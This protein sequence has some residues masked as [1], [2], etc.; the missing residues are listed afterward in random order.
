MTEHFSQVK[1]YGRQ[2]GSSNMQGPR[3]MSNDC[4]EAS[5]GLPTPAPPRGGTDHEPEG[6]EPDEQQ[7]HP[8][9]GGRV[10]LR[11]RVVVR[12]QHREHVVKLPSAHSLAGEDSVALRERRDRRAV[13][14]APLLIGRVEGSELLRLAGAEK[15]RDKARVLGKPPAA[16]LK[17]STGNADTRRGAVD[18]ANVPYE[19]RA[20]KAFIIQILK[21]ILNSG[22][23]NLPSTRAHIRWNYN[24]QSDS[25][26]P[27]DTWN[28]DVHIESIFAEARITYFTVQ[29]VN[30]NLMYRTVRLKVVYWA[31]HEQ[32]QKFKK[33]HYRHFLPLDLWIP[34]AGP[35]P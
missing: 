19:V 7:L 24:I 21:T 4:T 13:R 11:V 27:P 17:R 22:R 32:Y 25:R 10:H 12:D 16:A 33:T 31:H 15:P 20:F 29:S 34:S 9:L 2:K 18:G 23:H 1:L 30:N 8:D 28:T 14:Q 26:T 5:A 3:H 35:Q 6:H